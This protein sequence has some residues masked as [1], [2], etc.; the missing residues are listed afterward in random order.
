MG[1]IDYG[2][3][4]DTQ[5]HS[6]TSVGYLTLKNDGDE[7]IVRFDYAMPEDFDV[8]QIHSVDVNGK[9]RSVDCARQPADDISACKL[10]EEKYP[11]KT[12]FFARLIQYINT[13]EGVK[14]V[15]KVW[16]RPSKFLYTKL[17]TLC[18]EYG[19][20][21][22]DNV[23]KIKRCGAAGDKNTTYEILYCNPKIYDDAHYPKDFSG[24]EGFNLVGTMILKE[25]PKQTATE[26]RHQVEDGA[27][28]QTT[29][30]VRPTRRY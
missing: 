28:N 5:S 19:T 7:A 1:K 6:R 14:A 29:E 13:D 15:P 21:L 20:P 3:M 22:S 24:F 2:S 8:F 23:F 17:A 11:L 9:T 16:E 18:E 26:S 10:C 27:V 25:L 30:V 12:K 4:N